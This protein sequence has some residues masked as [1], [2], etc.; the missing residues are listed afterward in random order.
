MSI[1]T[2]TFKTISLFEII[3]LIY[4]SSG[5]VDGDIYKMYIL[6]FALA[7]HLPEQMIKHYF[8]NTPCSRHINLRPV[9]AKDCNVFNSGGP[10][11]P[12]EDFLSS[13][14]K[15]IE[16]LFKEEWDTETLGKPGMPSGHTSILTMYFVIQLCNVLY[17]KY[18][19]KQNVNSRSI[20]LLSIFS[21]L[22]LT[23]GIAR[24]G[25]KCHTT[26]QVIGGYFLGIILGII[27][28]YVSI[29]LCKKYPKFN[30]SFIN[31]YTAPYIQKESKVKTQ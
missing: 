10:V 17:I 29:V 12:T 11:G 8:K 6:C 20:A 18:K 13:K 21:V 7:K 14:D 31:F 30:D 15:R 25:L 26:E 19:L 2:S 22:V 16:L 28:F 24:V 5:V 23:I 27:A 4:F 9:G 1:K 3:F